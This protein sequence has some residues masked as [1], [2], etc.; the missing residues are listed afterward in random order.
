VAVPEILLSVLIPTVPWREEKLQRLLRRLDPQVTRNDVE[1]L[2]LRDNRSMSI[3]EKRNKLRTIA[4][5]RYLAFV[6]DDDMVADDYVATILAQVFAGF[7][8]INFFVNVK[9]HGPSKVCRYGLTLQH[10]NL[11]TEYHRKPNHLMVWKR[12]LATSVPFVDT[13]F[14]EDTLWAEAMGKLAKTEQTIPRVLY[15]Y[16]FD[17]KDNSGTAR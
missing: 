2:V 4:R 7:D 1:L 5:G 9:G 8:V 13:S 11:E 17:A 16:Q 15:T 6:D 12:E 3:G 10:A 14:G